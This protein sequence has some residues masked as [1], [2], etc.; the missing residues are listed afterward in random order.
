MA[1]GRSIARNKEAESQNDFRFNDVGERYKLMNRFYIISTTMMWALFVGFAWLKTFSNMIEMTVVYAIIG[2]TVIFILLNFIT[3]FKNRASNKLYLIV[4]VETA[5][6][7]L[8]LGITTDA[9]FVFYCMF[10]V[11]ALLVPYYDTKSFKIGAIAYGIIYLS[12]IVSRIKTNPASLNVDTMISVFVILFFVFVL[13]KVSTNTKLFSDH[14]L[15]SVAVQSEKQQEVFDGIV[16]TSKTVS[17]KAEESASLIGQLVDTTQSVAYSMQEITTAANMTAESIEE[18]NSMTQNIQI[19]IEETGER[20]KKMV[21]IAVESNQSIQDNIVVMQELKEQSV[22]IANTN[23]QVTSSM[24][25]LQNK[26]KEVEEITGMIL[27]I[28]NQTKMLALNAS[29]ESARAG[30]AGRG[31]AVV[32]DQIRQLA[33]QTRVSTEEITRIVSELNENANEVVASVASSIEATEMQNQKISDAS[34]AFENLNTNMATLIEDINGVDQQIYGLL[35][36]NNKIVENITQLSAATE[37]VTASAEQVRELS[38]SNLQFAEQVKD[39]IDVIEGTS[40]ELKQ[41]I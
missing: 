16:N 37:E 9:T 19:A 5:I 22:Q 28:S 4:M 32:A 2:L 20:S 13:I 7:V 25:R 41:Y 14:A 34:V 15:G 10:A 1:F 24:T 35:D 3:Y 33:E 26:T 31:F 21:D 30:E 40:E 38:E 6:E 27:N 8:V 11:L 23:H 36:A 12:I 29:I 39:S 17:I 18:Q